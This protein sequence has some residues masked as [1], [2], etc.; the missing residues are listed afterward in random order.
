MAGKKKGRK[1][2][3]ASYP[4]GTPANVSDWAP[5]EGFSGG[6]VAKSCKAI[7]N[8][9]RKAFSSK[10]ADRLCQAMATV[11]SFTL[12]SMAVATPRPMIIECAPPDAEALD[13]RGRAAMTAGS[14]RAIKQS[15]M[16]SSH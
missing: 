4:G 12:E 15:N 16:H 14:G 6:A 2:I 1:K 7:A 10:A 8:Q 3:T 9:Y 13:V 11:Q 5:P